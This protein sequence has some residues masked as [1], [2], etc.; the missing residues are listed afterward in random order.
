MRA[1]QI[2]SHPRSRTRTRPVVIAEPR[3]TVVESCEMADPGAVADALALLV[4]WA[5][6]AHRQ[7]EHSAPDEAA[8]LEPTISCS[9]EI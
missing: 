3:L 8:G 9:T 6:R 5:V 4:K 1:T 2:A 7:G